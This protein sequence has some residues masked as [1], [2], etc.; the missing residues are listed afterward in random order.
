ML[1]AQSLTD[2]YGFAFLDTTRGGWQE[3]SLAEIMSRAKAIYPAFHT[4]R[5]LML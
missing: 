3:L 5:L 1:V 2:Q 4:P